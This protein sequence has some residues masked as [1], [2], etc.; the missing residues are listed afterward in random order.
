MIEGFLVSLTVLVIVVMITVLLAPR[1]TRKVLTFGAICCVLST[2]IGYTVE[3]NTYR[4]NLAAYKATKEFCES[5][6]IKATQF[7]KTEFLKLVNASNREMAKT[8]IEI[9]AWWNFALPQ[10]LKVAYMEE[11]LI[12]VR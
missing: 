7:E 5:T 3:V 10:E 8:K 12:R 11:E 1:K 4:E 2:A 9:Q 6:D